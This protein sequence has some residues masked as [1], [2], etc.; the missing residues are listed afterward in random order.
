[1]RTNKEILEFDFESKEFVE[2][3][4]FMQADFLLIQIEVEYHIDTVSAFDTP[5]GSNDILAATDIEIMD[6]TVLYENENGILWQDELG[7]DRDAIEFLKK[8]QI[9]KDF[10]KNHLS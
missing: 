5:F 9:D 6:V 8:H 3:P 10:L 4:K 1:M 7:C 2:S